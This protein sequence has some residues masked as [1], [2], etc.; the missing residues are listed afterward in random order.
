[1]PP[2]S[3]LSSPP[4]LLAVAGCREAKEKLQALTLDEDKRK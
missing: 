1:M 3:P 4:F 2:A